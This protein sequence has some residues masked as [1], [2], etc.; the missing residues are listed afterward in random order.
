MAVGALPPSF[1]IGTRFFFTL[2]FLLSLLV[3]AIRLLLHSVL[4][5]IPPLTLLFGR[6]SP[7]FHFSFF[8]TS[9]PF[10]PQRGWVFLGFP[11]SYRLAPTSTEI[12]CFTYF[13]AF[14]FPPLFFPVT[15]EVESREDDSRSP[16]CLAPWPA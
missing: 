11:P 7:P 6:D 1:F 10:S 9:I 15:G 12:P 16:G 3:L 5:G 8:P 2:R 13:H 14:P 4:F